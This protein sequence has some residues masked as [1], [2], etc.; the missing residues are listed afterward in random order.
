MN[1]HAQPADWGSKFKRWRLAKAV[2]VIKELERWRGQPLA[3]AIRSCMVAIQPGIAPLRCR[4]G[5]GAEFILLLP[6]GWSI[7]A[8]QQRRLHRLQT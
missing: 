8:Q 7:S 1:Q 4:S 6:P 3:D 2:R 5:N